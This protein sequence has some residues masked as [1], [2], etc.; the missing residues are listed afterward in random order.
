MRITVIATGIQDGNAPEQKGTKVT[1]FAANTGTTRLGSE[2]EGSF[3]RPRRPKITVNE[4]TDLSVP[5]YIRAKGQSGVEER[6]HEPRK[7]VNG[8]D[9]AEFLFE[10]EEFEIPSFIRM[11][12]D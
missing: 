5:A 1:P 2:S 3:I 6:R 10:E 11:Q 8:G 12:A 4:S 9:D 7:I